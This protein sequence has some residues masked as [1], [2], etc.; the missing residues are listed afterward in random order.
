[1]HHVI[2]HLFSVAS[3]TVA[4]C[5]DWLW[6]YMNVCQSVVDW[7][8]YYV[9]VCQSVVDWLWY[10]MNVCQSVVDWL[11]YYVN[12]CQSV[13]DWLWYVSQLLIGCDITWMCVSQL[14]IGCDITWMCV[15]QLLIGCDIR[16]K[17]EEISLVPV[18]QFYEEANEEICKPVSCSLHPQLKLTVC[19]SSHFLSHDLIKWLQTSAHT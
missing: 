8:W 10:Y 19:T 13:V 18:E 4:W 3:L 6:Y 2:R 5:V 14:L 17:H 9:N 1:M 12:V 11:W 7:L 16:S 15:S